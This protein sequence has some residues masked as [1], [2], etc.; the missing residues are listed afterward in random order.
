[1]AVSLFTQSAL[2]FYSAFFAIYLIFFIFYKIILMDPLDL[3]NIEGEINMKEH[4]NNEKRQKV[5]IATLKVISVLSIILICA[6]PLKLLWY[7]YNLKVGKEN[8]NSLPFET[9]RSPFGPEPSAHIYAYYKFLYCYG[10]ATTE[11]AN[12][13]IP[14]LCSN[15]PW[16]FRR[17]LEDRGVIIVT[18]D[19]PSAA[20]NILR[21]NSFDSNTGGF[22]IDKEQYGRPIIFINLSDV[23]GKPAKSGLI[24]RAVHE[25]AH[26]IDNRD[27]HSES[28]EFKNY[29]KKYA[30]QYKPRCNVEDGYQKNNEADFFAILFTD[31]NNYQYERLDIPDELINYMEPIINSN[32]H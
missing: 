18:Y 31:I 19:L 4:L 5:F 8:L 7:Q 6:I 24:D 12:K 16:A 15:F 9:Y 32:K 29:F 22:H 21:K 14:H 25:L 28:Q 20:S 10:D 23:C 2:P 3:K 13:V 30:A 17:F 26:Y 27:E 11:D 1:M